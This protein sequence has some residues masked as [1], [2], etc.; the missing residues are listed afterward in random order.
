MKRGE[1][2]VKNTIA[3]TLQKHPDSLYAKTVPNWAS[4]AA[5]DTKPPSPGAKPRKS[6]PVSVAVPSDSQFIPDNLTVKSGTPVQAC[7]AGKWNP[8]TVIS[9]NSDGTLNFHWVKWGSSSDCSMVRSELIIHK[10]YLDP[11]YVEEVTIAPVEPAKTLKQYAVSIPVPADSQ[12]VP[13]D[14]KLAVGTKL[15]ACWAGKWNPITMLSHTP[16]GNL[17]VRWDD[18][19]PGFDCSMS[20][21][22]LIIKKATLKELMSLNSGADRA[23]LDRFNGQIQNQSEADQT[24]LDASNPADRKRKRGHVTVD[25][26]QQERSGFSALAE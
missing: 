17:N 6:Y 12:F 9:E 4:P 15:Q 13:K 3:A 1:L 25:E 10:K 18:F 19:G 24:L 8:L 20:R 2:I 11:N 14:A 23:N 16:D 5:K 26:V 21:Q 22:Q 7:W